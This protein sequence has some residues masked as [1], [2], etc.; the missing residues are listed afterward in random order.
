MKTK[1]NKYSYILL[2][3]F[4]SITGINQ[5]SYAQDITQNLV[6]YLPFECS[7]KDNSGNGYDGI[8]RGDPQCVT[9]KIGMAYKFDG[10]DDFIELPAEHTLEYISANGFSWSMWFNCSK[11]PTTM[12]AGP[13]SILLSVADDRLNEDIH[14]G[15]GSLLSRGNQF[16]FQ[17]DGLGGFGGSMFSP[18]TYQPPGNWQEN[19]WYHI[20][21]VRDYNSNQVILYLNG[22]EVARTT[23]TGDP[24]NRQMFAAVAAFFDGKPS[25]FFNG[26]I[27]EVRIYNR[28]ITPE[29]VKLIYEISPDNLTAYPNPLDFGAVFCS[30]DSSQFITLKNNSS[31][32]INITEI[33][34][35]R[36]KDFQ[37]AGSVPLDIAPNDSVK[38]NI[39]LTTQAAGIYYDT[40]IVK[41]RNTI[42]ELK[43]LIS[44]EKGNLSYTINGVN[45]NKIDFGVLCPGESKDTSF[46]ITTNASIKTKFFGEI[47]PP[48]SF[49][50]TAI[51]NNSTEF[52]TVETRNVP[53]H[54]EGNATEGKILGI[55]TITDPCDEKIYI[56]LT[57]DIHTPAFQVES[58]PEIEICPGMPFDRIITI[59]N[60]DN[61][62]LDFWLSGTNPLFSFQDT[63]FVDIGKSK[64][65]IV[66]FAGSDYGG[67][68]TTDITLATH[69]GI[70]TTITLTIKTSEI[71][72]GLKPDTLD[73]GDV[74]LCNP[75]TILTLGM[76]I[77]NE[78]IAIRPIMVTNITMPREFF[79]SMDLGEKFN[80]GEEQTYEVYFFPRAPGLFEGYMEITFDTCDVKKRFF[81]R[82]HAKNVEMQVNN[83]LDFGRVIIGNT[84]DSVIV[85]KNTETADLMLEEFFPLVGPQFEITG[86]SKTIPCVLAGGDSLVIYIRFKAEEG[87]FNDT[88][89]IK[90]SSPCDVFDFTIPI[91]GEGVWKAYV[92]II[93]PENL[94]AAPGNIL[95]LPVQ[96]AEEIDLAKSKIM[97]FK[98]VLS[99][100]PTLL[101]PKYPTPDG[102]LE[103]RRL[104]INIELPPE[105]LDDNITLAF[106][107]FKVALGNNDRDT[108]IISD[109][110]PIA[111]Y[112]DIDSSAGIFTLDNVCYENGPR[113]FESVESLELMPVKP[114]PAQDIA[115]I[116]FE[117]IEDAVTEV[118]II[119]IFGLKRA[120]ILNKYMKAGRYSLI[121]DI[122]QLP[123]GC[124]FYILKT[125]TQMK[126]GKLQISR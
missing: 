3:L 22:T 115:E 54:F 65:V 17:V 6:V 70:D 66:R 19:V 42:P 105:T 74:V 8:I 57:A 117:I 33:K 41:N 93:I 16:V 99:V 45:N 79:T 28:A 38:I 97:G 20:F 4:L 100:N 103:N 122:S 94:K 92:K 98:A 84:K 52:D 62:A 108:I 119:D 23:F 1:K 102:F 35:S 27:D 120:E 106:F 56:E 69:C 112:T 64:N 71:L 11:I 101:I 37:I 113:L 14:L 118:Y 91:Q 126:S 83:E 21:A 5:K 110:Y 116:E 40:L 85:F 58:P 73:F 9:G 7:P 50:D 87:I 67:T 24:I 109:I 63:V 81:I 111:G 31:A 49:L 10:I 86:L 72:I 59:K 48:F 39:L 121:F 53:I 125:L 95:N 36:G 44:A 90:G 25:V 26:I 76:S 107:P 43:V 13:S 34:L 78:N 29:E 68:Y 89:R 32:Y 15:F 60:K 2:I 96:L 51:A 77:T 61:Q 88:I 46:S 18:L 82:G 124:Y 75:D 55:M 30:K 104:K 47:S 12:A 114:N 123:T 80:I